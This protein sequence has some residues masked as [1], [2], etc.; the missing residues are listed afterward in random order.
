MNKQFITNNDVINNISDDA[1]YIRSLVGREKKA[2]LNILQQAHLGR[3]V[4]VFSYNHLDAYKNV[5]VRE[6]GLHLKELPW[7]NFI[8]NSA[9]TPYFKKVVASESVNLID[10]KNVLILLEG[11]K[12]LR[13]F[14]SHGLT[15]TSATKF[16]RKVTSLTKAG[17]LKNPKNLNL[18]D[19][20]KILNLESA[21]TALL[22]M[23]RALKTAR[24][25]EFK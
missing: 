7:D 2:N 16:E 25:N 8:N 22:G 23:G 14:I 11:L 20:D 9:L 6:E 5:I 24:Q 19:I 12:A 13:D 18:E 10:L 4:T 21:V 1:L 15:D 3:L 17:F